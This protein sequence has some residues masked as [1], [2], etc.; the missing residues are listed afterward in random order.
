MPIA[1]GGKKLIELRTWP[2]AT[3]LM[4]RGTRQGLDYNHAVARGAHP[5]TNGLESER[6]WAVA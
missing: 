2:G 4:T 1:A 3:R 6:Q 5:Y